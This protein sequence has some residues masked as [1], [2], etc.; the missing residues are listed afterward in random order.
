[1][2][3]SFF[4]RTLTW[5][6]GCLV[7]ICLL[8]TLTFVGGYAIVSAIVHTP[9]VTVPSVY[10]K[11]E[12]EAI[13]ILATAGLFIEVP[14]EY[15]E[16][17]QWVEGMVIEQSPRSGI[18]VKEGRKI[19][20]TVS[21]GAR[22]ILIPNLVGSQEEEIYPV[23][24]HWDLAAGQ[25]AAIYHPQLEPGVVIAQQPAPGEALHY[26][27]DVAILVSLGPRPK[28]Y[29]M[30]NRI[31][32]TVQET[33][34]LLE[35][36]GFQVTVDW[37]KV[38]SSENWD[39]VL[40]HFPAPGSKLTEGSEI[41]LTVGSENEKEEQISW[42]PFRYLLPNTVGG[43]YVILSITE[44]SGNKNTAPQTI[45]VPIEGPGYELSVPVPCRKQVNV[46]VYDGA[47]ESGKLIYKTTLNASDF[48]RPES[49]ENAPE[50][51]ERSQSEPVQET[52]STQEYPQ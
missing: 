13:K 31:E 12:T 41:I 50:I 24:Q 8:G 4:I 30:P 29:V 23:L 47:A 43:E 35:Q 20:L 10:G 44:L 51:P 42:L 16:S 46:E 52:P 28:S 1:M 40:D 22:R 2:A 34:R 21:K 6:T 49:T 15:Q 3:R 39:R 32:T 27:K 26:G 38:E 37:E 25:R 45:K 9:E 7:A 11:N 18:R 48:N 17:E 33:Q 5:G 19:R 36:M 14:I